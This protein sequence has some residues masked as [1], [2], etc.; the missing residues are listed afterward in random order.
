MLAAV[1]PKRTTRRRDGRATR[2]PVRAHR[3]SLK[4][5]TREALSREIA[6]IS[7][8]DFFGM[9]ADQMCETAW[10]NAKATSA[11]DRNRVDGMPAHLLRLCSTP[12]LQG[13]EESRLFQQMN[14]LKYRAN[15]LRSTLDVDRP[16]E[17]KL[18]Q[19]DKMLTAAACIR[20]RIVN[21][22][23]RLVVSIVRHLADNH[24]SF[25][26]LLSEGLTAMMRAVDKFDYDRGF[27]FSTY[28]TRIVRR[29]AFRMVSRRHRERSRLVTGA[30][31]VLTACSDEESPSRMTE[32]AWLTVDKTLTA[33]LERLDHRERLIV[34]AR[35]GL[36][37]SGARRTLRS[38]GL[39]LGVSKE[40]VRQ[41]EHRAVAKLRQFATE[42]D[43]DP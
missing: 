38:I 27:R 30:S 40:R 32:S 26:D 13:D 31:E 22:N 4:A 5:R 17:R 41:L 9:D 33:M 43:L 23:T 21:A 6:F 2:Q 11:S 7:N 14:F 20:N 42:T 1:K 35:Y 37:S 28:A 39:Q 18:D 24:N 34:R 15:V 16:D 12:L 8:P 29:E 25:D 3:D 36:D 19:I 10:E